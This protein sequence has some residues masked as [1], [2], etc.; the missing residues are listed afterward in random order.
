MNQGVIKDVLI[1]FDVRNKCIKW[2][3]KKQTRKLT[4][5]DAFIT[6]LPPKRFKQ[7]KKTPEERYDGGGVI[8]ILLTFHQHMHIF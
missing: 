4:L 2:Y 3:I 7:L 8:S 5:Q 1:Y 6:P